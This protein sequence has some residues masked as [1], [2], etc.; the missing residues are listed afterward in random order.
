MEKG[1]EPT[2]RELYPDFSDAEA[3][4]AE[5]NIRRFLGVIRRVA[6]RLGKESGRSHASPDLTD[7]PDRA[8]V[9]PERSNTTTNN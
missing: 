5:L 2:I 3:A 8:N 9:R 4:V 7:P 6:D 1:T